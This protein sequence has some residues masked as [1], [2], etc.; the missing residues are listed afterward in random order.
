MT[1]AQLD[2]P[3][4]NSISK[5]NIEIKKKKDHIKRKKIYYSSS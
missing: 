3:K 1:I 5:Q 2:F 4:S